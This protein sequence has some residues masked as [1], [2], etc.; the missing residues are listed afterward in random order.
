MSVLDKGEVLP[1][2]AGASTDE[3]KSLIKRST[4]MTKV[5]IIRVRR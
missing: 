2:F 1:I 5:L 3:W 4:A